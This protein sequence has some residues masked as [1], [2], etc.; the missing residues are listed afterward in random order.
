MK[1]ILSFLVLVVAF[2]APAMLEE[3]L[4]KGTGYLFISNEKDHTVTVLDG[5][6]FDVIKNIQTGRRPRALDSSTCWA[7]SPGSCHRDIEAGRWPGERSDG[8]RWHRKLDQG[9]Q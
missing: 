8:G 3:V 2:V 1:R 7:P 5:K 9:D 6:T 4:A